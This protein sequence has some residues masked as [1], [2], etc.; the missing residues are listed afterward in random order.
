MTIS[1]VIT[2]LLGLSLLSLLTQTALSSPNLVD[3][4]LQIHLTEW[5]TLP[6]GERVSCPEKMRQ[7]RMGS[8]RRS[9]TEA[10]AQKFR[11]V[12]S[13]SR[14]RG[15]IATNTTVTKGE[16]N[17]L[18][19]F[20]SDIQIDPTGAL[21]NWTMGSNSSTHCTTW[22]GVSCDLLG[23]VTGLDLGDLGLNGTITPRIGDLV[24]LSFL[25]LSDSSLWGPIPPELVRCRNL[26]VIDLSNNSL[27]GEVSPKLF[28]LP[29]LEWL[30][31]S[32]NRFSGFLP[33]VAAGGCRSLTYL[34]ISYTNITGA[35]PGSLSRCQNLTVLSLAGNQLSGGIPVWL[36]ELRQLELLILFNN[37]LTGTEKLQQ[38]MWAVL[39]KCGC[40]ME[41][42]FFYCSS[43]LSKTYAFV[44]VF[45]FT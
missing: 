1:G 40:Y 45:L 7:A 4:P 34:R 23:H 22:K 5:K 31:L 14:G 30:R 38:N 18:L 9:R 44:V 21:A 41:G 35:I 12:L 8:W 11:A 17:A 19:A 27:S 42:G 25:N 36:G 10:I 26:S 2:S 33:E 6:T 13:S 15:L 3:H 16:V 20:R 39:L 37:N 28:S 32:Y 29:E 43:T 24:H